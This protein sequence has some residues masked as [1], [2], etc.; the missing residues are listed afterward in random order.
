MKGTRFIL[1][2]Q[3]DWLFVVLT[4]KIYGQGTNESYDTK[5]WGGGAEVEKSEI[6][7][8]DQTTGNFG[9]K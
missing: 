6:R 5:T 4:L 2:R 1:A 7:A 8:S 3:K 9:G